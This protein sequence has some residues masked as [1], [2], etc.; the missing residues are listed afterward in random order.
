MCIRDSLN[1]L[2]RGRSAV[3]EILLRTLYLIFIRLSIFVVITFLFYVN[4]L[5]PAD[6]P[7]FL[8]ISSPTNLTPLPLYG[9]GLRKERILEQT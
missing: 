1:T 8:R 6:L 4:Y 2:I 9:S 3:P 5:A 7:D